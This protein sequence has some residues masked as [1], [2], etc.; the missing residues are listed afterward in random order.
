MPCSTTNW[1]TNVIASHVRR[2]PANENAYSGVVVLH[3]RFPKMS[4]FT[5]FYNGDSHKVTRWLVVSSG[6]RDSQMWMRLSDCSVTTWQGS[7]TVHVASCMLTV[8][9]SRGG[10]EAN[11][12]YFGISHRS[13]CRGRSSLVGFMQH[14]NQEL[15]RALGAWTSKTPPSWF[16]PFYPVNQSSAVLTIDDC[17]SLRISE[18]IALIFEGLMDDKWTLASSSTQSCQLFSSPVVEGVH[19]LQNLL[20]SAF[21][22]QN[23]LMHVRPSARNTWCS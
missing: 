9:G 22:Q 19:P 15:C 21:A 14:R 20:P 5:S 3:I 16:L 2:V 4:S 23:I 17:T 8:F 12:S 7:F 11:N 13:L 6:E 10:G 1:G 18:V